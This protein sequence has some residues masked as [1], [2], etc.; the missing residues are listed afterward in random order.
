LNRDRFDETLARWP[1]DAARRRLDLGEGSLAVLILGTVCD[2]KGQ[3]DLIEAFAH[4]DDE[5]ARRVTCFIV[6]DRP[7]AY[8]ERLHAARLSLGEP[9]SSRIR[10]IPETSDVALY[11]SAADLF[12]CSSRIESYPRVILEAMASGLPI[13]TTPVFGIREQVQENINALFY[14]P[15]NS[16]ALAE[17]IRRLLQD[18][19][20]R[21]RMAR[22]SHFVLAALDDYETMASTYGRIFLEAWLSGRPR[23]CVASSE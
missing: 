11:Y 2:R 19:N 14:P 4:M 13:I 15:G 18:S 16:H 7:G 22:N 21:S 1:R 10:I 17:A 5:S 20:L 3:S 6:G 12:V 8:S 9:L 23:P